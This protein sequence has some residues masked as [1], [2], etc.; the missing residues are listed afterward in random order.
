MPNT[1]IYNIEDTWNNESAVFDAIKINVTDTASDPL[2][3]LLDL[4]V[5]GISQFKVDKAGNVTASGTIAGLDQVDNVADLDKPVSTLQQAAID[6]AGGGAF[7]ADADTLI[8]PSTP[9]VLDQATGDEAALT[10]D[11]TTNKATSGDDT[12]LLINQTDTNSP[13]ASKL[14]DLQVGGTS[15][16]SVD[17]TGAVVASSI[18]TGVGNYDG[19][20]SSYKFSQLNGNFSFKDYLKVKRGHAFGWTDNINLALDAYLTSDAANTIS[21]RNG[22]NAQTY[23]IYNAYTSA[24]NYER[25]HIGWNDTSNAFVIGTEEGSGG[26]VARSLLLT[27]NNDVLMEVNNNTGSMGGIRTNTGVQL[28]TFRGNKTGVIEGSN[29]T[30]NSLPTSDPLTAGKLWNDAGTLKLGGSG[31][32]GG[33]GG[34][35]AADANTQ[36]TPSTAIVLDQ[37]TG[38]EAALSLDYTTNKLTSG[39]DTGLQINLTDTNSPGTSKLMDLQVGGV[40]KVS[41]DANGLTISSDAPAPQ[42]VNKSLLSPSRV[43]YSFGFFDGYP[44]VTASSGYAA[45]EF[46]EG[47]KVRSG[48]SLAFS[49]SNTSAH[50]GSDLLLTRS[51]AATLQL[52][53]DHAT[54]PTGQ[55][56]KAHDVAT[57]AGADLTLSGGTGSVADGDV[58]ID[59]NLASIHGDNELLRLSHIGAANDQATRA[60]VTYYR[61]AGTNRIG[62]SGFSGS[63]TFEIATDY[64]AGKFRLRTGNQVE[65]LLVD[66]AGD[67]TFAK[68]VG[69]GTTPDANAALDVATTWNN[70]ATTFTGI[71]A[72]VTDTASA[73]GSK[74]MDLQVG[75]VS[76]FSVS[77]TG[78]LRVATQSP[79]YLTPSFGTND[80]N[81]GLAIWSNAKL[82]AVCN[83]TGVATFSQSA[84]YGLMIKGTLPLSWANNDVNGA[85]DLFLVRE[86]AATL[87]LGQD[88]AT[89]ATGQTIKA[90][91]VASGT[92]ADLTLSGGTGSTVDGNVRLVAG[93]SSSIHLVADGLARLTVDRDSILARKPLRFAT[94]NTL[95][96]GTAG[97][98]PRSAYLGTTLDVAQ[99]TLTNDAQALNITSTWNDAADT[100]TLIK[101]DVTDTASAAGSNLM[102]LQ[103]GGTSKFSVDP[104]GTITIDPGTNNTLIQ[105]SSTA[106]PVIRVRTGG[107][108]HLLFGIGSSPWNY[109]TIGFD[110]G[111]K[112][113]ASGSF[114][115]SS[116]SVDSTAAGDLF[117]TRDSA[118]TLQL[119]EDHAT[120]ATGQTIK[121]HD[122]ATGTGADLTLSGGTGSV[123][124]GDIILSGN[125]R[126]MP[127]GA[128]TDNN[129]IGSNAGSGNSGS[130][131]AGFGFQSL[132]LNTGDNNT[133]TGWLSLDSNTGD[134]NTADGTQ[135]LRSNS[136]N[137]NSGFGYYSLYF[138]TGSNNTAFGY[139]SLQNNTG[140]DNTASGY[141]SLQNNSGTYNSASGNYSL[142][143]N[144]GTYNTA[145]GSFS[146]YQ[147]T[148]NENTA[149]GY[150]SLRQN[151]G[152]GNT[153]SGNQSGTYQSGTTTP[154]TTASNSVFLGAITKG[155]QG[156]TNQIVIGD[157]AES[158]GANTVVLGNDSIV[159]TALK[160]TVTTANVDFTN[161]AGAVYAKWDGASRVF[162]A[163]GDAFAV[164]TDTAE[165]RINNTG[166]FGW[167]N[168]V[169]SSG[170]M[171]LILR[172]AA[173]ATLQ[174]GTD[175]AT[176]ATGQTIKA[177]D[178]VTGTGADLTLSGGTGSVADGNIILDC[179]DVILKG[180]GAGADGTIRLGSGG[181][182]Y[183]YSTSAGGALRFGVGG[184]TRGAWTTTGLGIGT[185]SPNANAA[186]DVSSTTK[187]FL[188]PRMTTTEKNA[189]ASPTA[190]MVVY[191]STLNKLA[192]Y[193]GA[194]WEAITS[195]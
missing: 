81:S 133:A 82:T 43:G 92:G 30:I 80:Y 151:T 163:G 94:D 130:Q 7:D 88:H 60:Y 12:G 46:Y 134:G 9:I 157:T 194:A 57:G 10:L 146:L 131:N 40:S 140:N 93:G 153:A 108:G 195:A 115:W 64:A 85:S 125:V 79:S 122:V 126:A 106:D 124:N 169:A 8:T 127:T 1:P 65:A 5:G 155:V 147:N 91:D 89:V 105:T 166:S 53:T 31:S 38:N 55:T 28:M 13:G 25:A 154:L 135:T 47:V 138:N 185:P 50:V 192:V 179:A 41:V 74:L 32:G 182:A 174:L 139:Q 176:V 178:V 20:V 120:V 175:H 34:A 6:A 99:G 37:A 167:S 116:A 4:K 183:L 22:V 109:N 77:D 71:K 156:A 83:G 181:N 152:T 3:K 184:S 136:G 58:V 150:D 16:F 18:N 59:A 76:Q 158:I 114:Q 63:N 96:I 56:I 112:T 70:A 45:T 113:H 119:G 14:V 61:G 160:G 27:G 190:G 15:K 84:S 44:C 172:K 164:R 173:A 11:Y 188:P 123:A 24:T 168:S 189:V 23:N 72:D 129:F 143:G 161:T 2:S 100:F 66:S 62:Y 49:S 52:G 36:I 165:T 145:S 73:A 141:L 102:D 87:Q 186:L 187:A 67:A 21:Q 137:N 180:S 117:L 95:D 144:T 103:V 75:G 51:A 33:G 111:F 101:A 148:G 29:L 17:T 177:H 107:Y 42:Y 78:S 68:S 159:T 98:R 132:R 104:T 142:R 191:D 86:S 128:G 69:I 110:V 54:T 97:F 118:A 170:S 193:T 149:S 162:Y 26:G 48:D 35:F 121:A 171:D 39:D 90:H 19:S